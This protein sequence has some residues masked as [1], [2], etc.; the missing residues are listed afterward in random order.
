MF[1]Y[2]LYTCINWYIQEITKMGIGG[3]GY[4]SAVLLTPQ[5]LK[6]IRNLLPDFVTRSK[7]P[8]WTER[9]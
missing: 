7:S 2:F 3:L 5:G 8:M 1:M 6:P 9:I 4:K